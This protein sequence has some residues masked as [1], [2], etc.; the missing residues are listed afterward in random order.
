MRRLNLFAKGNVD[1]RDSLL[2]S[3]VG[4]RLQWNGLNEIVRQAFPGHL[5]R[6]RHETWTRSDALTLTDGT[7]PAALRQKALPLDPY[8]LESQFSRKV[9]ESASD[10]VVLSLQPDVFTPLVRHREDAFLFYPYAWEAWPVADQQWLGE[11]FEGTGHLDVDASMG[12]IA[13]ICQEVRASVGAHI[14]I[15]NVSAVVPGEQIHCYHGMGETLSTRIRRFNLGLVELAEQ[16][17][18]SVVDVD[19]LVACAGATRVRIGPVHLTGEGYRLV[20][21]EVTRILQDL[22]CFD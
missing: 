10:V 19:A 16:L 20:A 14:L 11:R 18:I 17:D 13:R 5:I 1:V 4:G 9:F 15:Y 8:S 3:S 2:Y 21:Q 7:I 12:H 6:V 22:G